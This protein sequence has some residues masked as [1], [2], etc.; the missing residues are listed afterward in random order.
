MCSSSLEFSRLSLTFVSFFLSVI[1]R[2]S[3]CFF[4]F[5]WNFEREIGAR[6]AKIDPLAHDL[7]HV[8]PLCWFL[9]GSKN[10]FNA[11]KLMHPKMSKAR[12][13]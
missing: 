8:F 1:L 11:F 9:L 2:D 13:N 3:D 4:C 6:A 10:S 5:P 12:P 7:T